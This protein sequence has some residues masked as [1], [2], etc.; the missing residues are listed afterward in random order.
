MIDPLEVAIT[1]LRQTPDLQR[2]T[3]DRISAKHQYGVTWQVGDAAIVVSLDGGTP[4]LDLPRQVIQL[5]VRCYAA[6]T[7][8]ALSLWLAL[9]ALTRESYRVRVPTANGTAL[10]YRF[11]PKSGPSTLYDKEIGSD[12]VLALF[13][14][15]VAE[16]A[17]A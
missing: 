16:A 8:V 3:H 4:D 14:L 1:Y 13:V 5:D 9:A 10:V 17:V 2:L 12:V 7:Q 15:D 11:Q 6:S